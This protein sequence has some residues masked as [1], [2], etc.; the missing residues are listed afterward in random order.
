[1]S[2]RNWF[3][4]RGKREEMLVWTRRLLLYISVSRALTC[5]R[6]GHLADDAA[7]T[8]A[9]MPAVYKQRPNSEPSRLPFLESGSER[10]A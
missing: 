5:S 8:R 2:S 4:E 6:P 10:E 7:K 9:T 1:M 3:A